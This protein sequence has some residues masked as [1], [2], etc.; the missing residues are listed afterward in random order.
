MFKTFSEAGD[1]RKH[2]RK[3]SQL[4]PLKREVEMEKSRSSRECGGN[5]LLTLLLEIMGKGS[6]WG[7]R[8]FSPPKTLVGAE[9]SMGQNPVLISDP[10]RMLF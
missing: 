10:G 8:F 1:E 6:G 5:V 4:S 7:G 9:S 2:G 3:T